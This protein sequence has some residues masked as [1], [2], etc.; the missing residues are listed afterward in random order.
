MAGVQSTLNLPTLTDCPFTKPWKKKPKKQHTTHVICP[1]R[2]CKDMAPSW[3]A[4]LI[5]TKQAPLRI[6]Y[7]PD[8][9]DRYPR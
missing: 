1:Q 5:Q 7:E 6:Y 8:Y 2:M 4:Q 9:K 3:L